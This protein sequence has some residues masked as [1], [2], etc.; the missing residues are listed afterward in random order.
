MGVISHSNGGM[1]EGRV[2]CGGW[3]AYGTK[4]GGVSRLLIDAGALNECEM[5]TLMTSDHTAFQVRSSANG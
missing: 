1:G 3:L 4:P 2:E 5:K